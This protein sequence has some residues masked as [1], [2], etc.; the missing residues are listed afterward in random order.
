MTG[1]VPHHPFLRACNY[2]T[3]LAGQ[4]FVSL[5]FLG[6]SPSVYVH[7][8]NILSLALLIELFYF[9]IKELI[10]VRLFSIFYSIVCAYMY[11]F[12]HAYSMKLA[13][14]LWI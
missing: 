5:V 3:E 14:Y 9:G 4:L 6:L 8:Q 1:N 2:S 12:M 7:E 11:V 13:D 10:N